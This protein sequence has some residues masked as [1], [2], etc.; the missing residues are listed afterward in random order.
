MIQTIECV[1]LIAPDVAEAQRETERQVD[2]E[3]E[4]QRERE[5][6]RHLNLS[7][8]QS[9]DD[10]VEWIFDDAAGA[11]TL[12]LRHDVTDDALVDDGVDRHPFRIGQ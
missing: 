8:W 6:G 1:S 3:T 2:K 5:T 7:D 4:R 11:G 10:L 9:I 12:E